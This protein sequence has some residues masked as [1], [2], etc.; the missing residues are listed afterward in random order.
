MWG[1]GQRSD[2]MEG[3]GRGWCPLPT[4]PRWQTLRSVVGLQSRARASFDLLRHL[5]LALR[6]LLH[7]GQ[8]SLARFLRLD[9]LLLQLCQLRLRLENRRNCFCTIILK[10]HVRH[11]WVYGMGTSGFMLIPVTPPS[12]RVA[13]MR[14]MRVQWASEHGL[15]FKFYGSIAQTVLNSKWPSELHR[16]IRTHKMH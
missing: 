7:P 5:F 3:V 4:C 11:Q 13:G 12:Q 15:G 16:S 6:L 9:H 10:L 1:S 14:K 8:S 2:R